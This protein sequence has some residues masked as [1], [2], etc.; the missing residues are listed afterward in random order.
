M[1]NHE[2]Q[3]GHPTNVNFTL[4]YKAFNVFCCNGI[5]TLKYHIDSLMFALMS[6]QSLRR[7]AWRIK[8]RS[9]HIE[10]KTCPLVAADCHEQIFVLGC[11][12]YRGCLLWLKLTIT[13]WRHQMEIISALLA[14]C[15]GNSPPSHPLWRHCNEISSGWSGSCHRLV[16]IGALI[17]S[18]LCAWTDGR[19]NTQDAGHLRRYCAHYDAT[20]MA[21][22]HLS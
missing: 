15:A 6:K 1:R 16:P 11:E 20:V 22:E 7:L 13:W 4:I 2:Y 21:I 14:L 18:L 10:G 17:F 9:Q 5:F 19:A 3:T 12:Y 8:A